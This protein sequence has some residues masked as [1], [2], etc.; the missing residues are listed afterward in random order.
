MLLLIAYSTLATNLMISKESSH[1]DFAK[2]VP[3]PTTVYDVR[4]PDD[5]IPSFLSTIDEELGIVALS[6]TSAPPAYP[7]QGILFGQC[8]RAFVPLIVS[9]RT[10]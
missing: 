5:I 9:K 10:K 6:E 8:H 7:V 4:F 1:L 2:P 3:I